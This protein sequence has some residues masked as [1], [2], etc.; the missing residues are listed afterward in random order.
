MRNCI[1]QTYPPY[2]SRPEVARGQNRET[3]GHTPFSRR[4]SRRPRRVRGCAIA[5]HKRN[6]P[7][8]SRPEVARGQNRETGGH[9][10]NA[11]PEVTH[12]SAKGGPD[13]HVGCA[14]AQLH[15]TNVPA[16]HL[17]TGGS[18][19]PKPRDRRSR[20]KRETG[21][22][23]PFSKRGSPTPT[24]GARM[25]NCIPH[26]YPPYT[27]RPEVARGQ[28][29]ETGGHAPNA[30]PEVTHHSAKGG[31]RRPRRVR[32]CAIASHTRTRRTP[33]DRR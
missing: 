4:G 30:R 23:A 21:G 24:S 31:P 15:P 10:P 26:T 17:A 27:S 22:H 19:R 1:P 33:R 7:Y 14:D 16:V 5:S 28:N 18:A 20:T 32:G 12:H 6:P 9:A 11:R 25:R 2:T 13:A 29:R 8:T 3:G